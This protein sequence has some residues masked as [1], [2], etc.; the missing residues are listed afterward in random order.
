MASRHKLR[1]KR[2]RRRQRALLHKAEQRKRVQESSKVILAEVD[3][4]IARLVH[5]LGALE[6]A[7]TVTL[8]RTLESIKN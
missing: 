7:R 1:L 2:N 3:R 6:K 8:I 5:T 4:L